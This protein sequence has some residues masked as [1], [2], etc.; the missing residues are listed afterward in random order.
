MLD[1]SKLTDAELCVLWQ[2][3]DMGSRY[4]EQALLDSGAGESC[5]NPAQ[6]RELENRC[7]RDMWRVVHLEVGRRGICPRSFTKARLVTSTVREAV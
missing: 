6:L 2:R 5:N 3:L 4:F 7:K 1:A